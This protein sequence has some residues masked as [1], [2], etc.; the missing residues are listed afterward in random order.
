MATIGTERAC[1][2]ADSLT[3][4]VLSTTS[5]VHRSREDSKTRGLVLFASLHATQMFLAWQQDCSLK[6]WRHFNK[7]VAFFTLA[8]WQRRTVIS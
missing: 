2:V 1:S 8:S 7:G 3:L 5:E 4:F 6:Y